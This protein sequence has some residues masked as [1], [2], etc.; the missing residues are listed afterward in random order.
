MFVDSGRPF[1]DQAPLLST[2]VHLS[3]DTAERLWGE[4]LRVGW[5]PCRPQWAADAEF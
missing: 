4:L 5:I 3:Q 1:P 2:R